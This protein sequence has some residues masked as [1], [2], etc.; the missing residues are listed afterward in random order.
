MISFAGILA[1]C[2]LGGSAVRKV[3]VDKSP[4]AVAG[5]AYPVGAGLVTLAMFAMN[6]LGLR[7]NNGI[8]VFISFAILLWGIFKIWR[9]GWRHSLRF[10]LP[11]WVSSPVALWSL[12]LMVVL[13]LAA[14]AV[15]SYWPVS[16]WD[17][18]PLYDFRGKLWAE[19]GFMALPIIKESDYLKSFPPMISLLHSWLYLHGGDNPHVLHFLFWISF[20]V[21]SY[22]AFSR[23][24]NRVLGLLATLFL[25]TMPELMRHGM[26]AYT[27]LPSL[28]FFI[29]AIYPFTQQ[30]ISLNNAAFLGF[31]LGLAGWTR[32]VTE[33][34][35]LASLAA[36]AIISFQ[37]GRR[38]RWDTLVAGCMF[39]AVDVL[40]PFYQLTTLGG[41]SARYHNELV[42]FASL[43]DGRIVNLA[44]LWIQ[45]AGAPGLF[46][47]T[48]VLFFFALIWDRARSERVLL[49]VILAV[50]AAWML[51]FL[52][53]DQGDVAA[54]VLAT[55]F[56]VWMPGAALMIFWAARSQIGKSLSLYLDDML[57]GEEVG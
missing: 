55:G 18:V 12:G 49:V 15:A 40:W 33:P 36:I 4:F 21:F 50:W 53:V 47:S 57:A 35:T 17:D 29:A 19:S 38:I 32:Y 31:L 22:G 10:E 26:I 39:L 13:S 30:S 45:L 14:L 42:S 52:V 11:T 51:T 37:Q 20:A 7:W 2:I 5:L 44:G 23:E 28:L 43:L 3:Y 48:L 24:R 56:R 34:M 54:F 41:L 6:L 46:G 9:G 1:L 16:D 8:L 27:N 25:I